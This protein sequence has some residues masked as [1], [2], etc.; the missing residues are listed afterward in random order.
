MNNNI[1]YLII[2]NYIFKILYD[3]IFSAIN[4]EALERRLLKKSCTFNMLF[5]KPNIIRIGHLERLYDNNANNI[6]QIISNTL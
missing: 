6:A 3:K 1:I 4:L 2:L 5:A